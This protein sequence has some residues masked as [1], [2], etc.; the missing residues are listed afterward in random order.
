[1]LHQ[2]IF[3]YMSNV[4]SSTLPFLFH[5]RVLCNIALCLVHFLVGF[6]WEFCVASCNCSHQGNIKVKESLLL[7]LP[8]VTSGNVNHPAS[9][10]YL[11]T[12]AYALQA[13]YCA[14]IFVHTSCR[15]MEHLSCE[16]ISSW[17]WCY[18]MNNGHSW[19]VF[20]A[21]LHGLL[22]RQDVWNFIHN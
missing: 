10:Y 2:G 8:D 5:L 7:Y 3:V 17:Y 19:T 4:V 20:H 12:S 1:M 11:H 21:T 15:W 18:C 22:G 6:I 14:R 13:G 9:V 16:N